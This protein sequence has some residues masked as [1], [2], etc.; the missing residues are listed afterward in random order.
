[1]NLS[2]ERP[3]G[4]ARR[5]DEAPRR[6]AARPPAGDRWMCDTG[7]HV[8]AG[9]LDRLP[10]YR[11]GPA[12]RTL[13]QADD[14]SRWGAPPVR[15]RRA[16]TGVHR[17][18]PAGLLHH[19]AE[20]GPLR[21]GT[22]AVAPV[23]RADDHRPAHRPAEGGQRRLPRRRQRLGIRRQRHHPPRRAARHP[24][25]V[26]VGRRHRHVRLHR[27]LRGAHRHPADGAISPQ[28]RANSLVGSAA[29]VSAGGYFGGSSG[30]CAERPTT[31]RERSPRMVITAVNT[32]VGSW[33]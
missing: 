24:R 19:D 16:G 21:R 1:M 6:A 12:A 28:V 11:P 27:P 17:R 23:G 10:A 7:F 32:V 3:G 26:R 9:K 22:R 20:P 33:T 5:V 29:E 13:P 2:V 25:P 18:R 30:T 15:G 8:P 4:R 31:T 14:R